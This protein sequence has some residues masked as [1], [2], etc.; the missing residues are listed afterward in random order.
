MRTVPFELLTS[1]QF[2]IKELF[3]YDE[4]LP[5]GTHFVDYEPEP[6]FDTEA[7]LQE[8]GRK[9]IELSPPLDGVLRDWLKYRI[10]PFSYRV[11]APRNILRIWMYLPEVA[12]ILTLP[13]VIG[14]FRRSSNTVTK[15]PEQ[16]KVVFKR[17]P[18]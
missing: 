13:E 7:A 3:A 9:L 14:N 12:R 17:G 16:F 1:E 15:W 4:S 8:A 2:A 6:G 18:W 5:P 10:Q 11:I